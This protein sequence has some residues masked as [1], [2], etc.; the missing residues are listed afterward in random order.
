MDNIYNKNKI[1]IN[2]RLFQKGKSGIPHYIECLYTELLKI[3][4]ENDY[5]FFQIEE[6]KK[7][8]FTKIL[9]TNNGII[10]A[11]L[12]DNFLVNYLIKKEK[13]DIFHGPSCVLPIIKERGVKYVVTVHDLAFLKIPQMHGF[14]FRIY[15]KLALNISLNK[16]DVIVTPSKSTKNDIMEFFKIEESKIKVIHLGVDNSFRE[17][18]YKERIIKERYFFSLTTHP[19]RKNIISV[20]DVMSKNKEFKKYKYIIVGMIGESQLVKLNDLIKRLGLINNV[21]VWGYISKDQLVNFYQNA[22]FFIYP[23]FYEGFGFPVLEAMTCKCPVITSNNSSLVEI[24]PNSDWLVDPYDLENISN[25][26]SEM[27][28]L[29]KEERN[30]LINT[31][32]NFSKQFNWN[33]TAKEYIKLFAALK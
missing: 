13:I 19:K 11:F 14:L 26:I 23:S 12:F 8:G 16:A 3:D 4:K 22:E 29:G 33:K 5:T 30:E 6:N 24:T 20:L 32:Y 10:G 21:V 27:I 1:G 25:K 15:Y 2:S 28:K 18:D 17:A 31:N 9:K 7:I